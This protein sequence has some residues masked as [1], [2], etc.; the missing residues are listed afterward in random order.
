MFFVCT[1]VLFFIPNLE[2]EDGLII[3]ISLLPFILVGLGLFIFLLVRHY[4]RALLGQ[5]EIIISKES[6]RLGESFDVILRHT[7]KRD[8]LLDHLT[9][10]FLFRETAT[11]QQ[12]TDTTTV[13]HNEVLQNFELPGGQYRAGQFIQQNYDLQIPLDGMHTLVVERNK[14]QWFIRLEAGISNLPNYVEE[15]E[16]TVLPEHLMEPFN[17]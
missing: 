12:G 9:V 6:L 10:Q 5:P 16:L 14:L 11:Y 13:S 4:S 1:P 2:N 3:L 15:Y 7:F 8:V 17:G